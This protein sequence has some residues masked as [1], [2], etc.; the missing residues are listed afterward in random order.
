MYITIEG[1]QIDSFCVVAMSTLLAPEYLCVK[2]QIFKF[3]ALEVGQRVLLE[4]HMVRTFP[5]SLH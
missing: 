2:N 4:P 3:A 5:D 1:K